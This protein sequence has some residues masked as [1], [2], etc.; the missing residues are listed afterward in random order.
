MRSTVEDLIARKAWVK[1]ERKAKRAATKAR[2][3]PARQLGD[4]R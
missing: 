4:G 1:A 2:E 3:S